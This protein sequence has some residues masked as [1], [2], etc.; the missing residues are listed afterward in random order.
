M[1]NPAASPPALTHLQRR[2]IDAAADLM[3]GNADSPEFMHSVLCH[4]GMPRSRT[5]ARTFERSSGNAS[6]MI[7]AGR[8]WKRKQWHDQPLP[9]GAKP[10]LVLIHLCSE[11][12]RTGS[13]DVE[14]GRSAREFLGRLG[15]D[16][17]GHEYARFRAQME[18]LA[19]CRM[20]L[21][22][23]TENRDVTISTNPISRFEAWMQH[24][25]KSLGLWPGMM[26]LS[27]EFHATLLEHAVP[28][29][30]RAI[31]ALQHSALALDVYTWLAHRLCRVRTDNGVKLYWKNLREQ[32]GQE[33]KDPKNFKQ[34]FKA[35]LL[36][37][38]TVYPD[39]N[40]REETGGIR[41]YP[42][43]PPI[44]KTQVTVHQLAS[45]K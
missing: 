16:D 29:D 32:F 13:P 2:I 14:V 8:L 20:V 11:A 45:A 35:A 21:G 41:L 39:A 31:G 40:V 28:L 7:E 5:D 6:I 19:A 26:T 17:G 23:S 36:K 34:E 24:D 33:Y 27:G 1:D 12:V 44:K 18:S 37:V 30:P 42:S 4:V 15:L 9:Y 3:E 43:T 25:E 22:F 38:C 10:R